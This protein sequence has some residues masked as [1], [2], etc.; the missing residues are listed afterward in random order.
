[1]VEPGCNAGP[2]SCEKSRYV[3]ASEARASSVKRCFNCTVTLCN[4]RTDLPGCCGFNESS[5]VS[6]NG[7]GSRNEK[8]R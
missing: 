6:R 8:S 3:R 7:R 1:M 4:D 5:S 2:G